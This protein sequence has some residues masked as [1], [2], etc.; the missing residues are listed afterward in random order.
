M[1]IVHIS[2]ADYNGAGLCAYRICKA[3]R[4]KGIDSQMV[5]LRKRQKDKFIHQSGSKRYFYYSTLRKIKLLLNIHDEVNIVKKLG[6]LHKAVYTL[7]ISPIK[8][9]HLKEF[10]Q[11][12]LIHIHWV[13]GYLDYPSFF[14]TFKDKPIVFT[15]HDEN[16]LYGIANIEQQL[17]R[18]NTLE[19]K[20]RKLKEDTLEQVKKVGFVFLSKTSYDQYCNYK[21]VKNRQKTIIYNSVDCTLFRP[22]NR[23][24]ARKQLGISQNATIFAFCACNIDEPRKKL[25]EL[26]LALKLINPDYRILAIGKNRSK[27]TWDNVIEIGRIN[28][29]EKL[30]WAFSAANYF[31]LPSFQETFGQVVIEAMACGIPAIMSPTD[32]SREIITPTNGICCKD[33]TTESLEE[34]IRKALVTDY[35]ANAIRQDTITRFSPEKICHDYLDFYKEVIGTTT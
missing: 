15:L 7:P 4:K 28:N 32:A 8:Q 11:A 14:E 29:A 35:D 30:S 27:T 9:R 6:A 10:L 20:Y 1:K 24:E 22:K 19:D 17:L 26:S 13:G 3:Q 23:T 16:A 25:N 34:G 5:V 12:D 21:M 18:D 33:F 31:V 2:M